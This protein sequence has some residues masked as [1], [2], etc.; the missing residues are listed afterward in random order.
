[1]SRAGFLW[2]H[3]ENDT[4][5]RQALDGVSIETLAETHQRSHSAIK[6][7]IVE[8]A[9]KMMTANTYLRPQDIIRLFPMITLYDIQVCLHFQYERAQQK[10]TSLSVMMEIRDCLQ[11]LVENK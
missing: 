1:M 2:T 7:R 5:M 6:I 11:K 3:A 4:V 8:N 9:I 10:P